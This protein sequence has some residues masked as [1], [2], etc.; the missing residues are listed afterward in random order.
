MLYSIWS[1]VSCDNVCMWPWYTIVLYMVRVDPANAVLKQQAIDQLL[2]QPPPLSTPY[3]LTPPPPPPTHT[4]FLVVSIPEIKSTVCWSLGLWSLSDFF[5]GLRQRPPRENK[6]KV[7]V[8]SHVT[9]QKS[10]RSHRQ[11]EV[12]NIPRVSLQD[13]LSYCKR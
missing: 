11:N 4:P 7:K 2:T 1:M 8:A 12:L 6:L 13:Q 10:P 9:R 5:T 3:W